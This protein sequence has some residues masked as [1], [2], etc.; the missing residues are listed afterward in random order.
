M[1]ILSEAPIDRRLTSRYSRLFAALQ[2]GYWMSFCSLIGFAVVLLTAINFSAGQVGTILAAASLSSIA[3][4]PILA[5]IVSRYPRY[6]LHRLLVASLLA[7]VL[8]TLLLL[9]A[10][11]RIS[12]TIL[13]FVLI[14]M[15]E[16]ALQSFIS[17]FFLQYVNAGYSLSFGLTR[18]IGSISYALCGAGMGFLIGRAGHSVILPVHIAFLLATIVIVVMLRPPE[19]VLDSYAP[20]LFRGDGSIRRILADNPSVAGLMLASILAFI[21][22]N[23]LTTFTPM[24]IHHVDG[25]DA[26][27]GLVLFLTAVSESP[28]M[29]LFSRLERRLGS[30]RLLMISFLFLLIKPVLYAISP[31]LNTLLLVQPIQVA[32]FGLFIPASVH[33][34]NDVLPSSQRIRGQALLSTAAFGI[35]MV[36]ANFAGGW[37]IEFGGIELFFILNISCAALGLMIILFTCAGTRKSRNDLEKHKSDTLLR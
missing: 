24:I 4:Q 10:D 29:F 1:T 21:S 27:L 6:G 34:I 31:N 35:G 37:I 23:S 17:S 28:A 3:A 22:Y 8:S 26:D 19:K 12:L 36:V 5:A 16:I 14:G 11:G 25:T 33:Y 15:T 2:S 9:Q 30:A 32:G 13:A 18:G 20:S 7:A